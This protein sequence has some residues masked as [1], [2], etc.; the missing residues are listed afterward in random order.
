[1][2]PLPTVLTVE[3]KNVSYSFGNRRQDHFSTTNKF[4]GYGFKS[5]HYVFVLTKT[6]QTIAHGFNPGKS[7][8]PF[9]ICLK[10][11]LPHQNSNFVQK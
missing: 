9:I 3:T 5:Y 11:G 1:M 6:L 2:P 7:E 10:L 4:V 8:I